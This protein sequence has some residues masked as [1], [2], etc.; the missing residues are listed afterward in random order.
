MSDPSQ[1]SQGTTV[2]ALTTDSGID[3]LSVDCEGG[4]ETTLL[5]LTS[6]FL[7][8][9]IKECSNSKN[10]KMGWLCKWCG[11]KFSPRH[12]SRAIRHVLKI[13]LGDIVICTVSIPKE[14]EDRYR[15]LY[16]RSTEQMQT[17][18]CI[19]TDIEDAL[20]MKQTAAIVNLLGKRGVAISGG[21]IPYSIAAKG[22][23][24]T[25]NSSIS[26]YTKGGS[27]TKMDRLLNLYSHPSLHP[28]R[29]WTS[30]SLTMQ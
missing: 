2:S 28:S 26:F 9:F 20:A 12:Q 23:L 27:K 25:S 7:C 13:K 11:K 8:P 18:K 14:Y 19:H 22:N 6:I 21:T 1:Q 17:K 24:V 30:A 16:A 5:L 3:N 10:G 15:A 4:E 29:T